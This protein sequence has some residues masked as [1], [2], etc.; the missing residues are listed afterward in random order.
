[1]TPI[2][3]LLAAAADAGAPLSS[4]AAALPPRATMSD[5]LQEVP[6]TRSGPFLAALADDAE[7][8][9]ELLDGLGSVSAVDTLDGV[10]MT[11]DGGDIV[12]FRASGNAPELR[13][14]TECATPAEAERLLR[15]ALAR[16]AVRLAA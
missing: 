6:D 5:R 16:A 1:M 14:Y 11:L 13:C 7:A 15:A 4:L 2:L 3:A 8:R 10:R 9:A 12:H